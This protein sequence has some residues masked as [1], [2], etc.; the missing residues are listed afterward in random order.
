MAETSRGWQ[1]LV[2]KPEV[3]NNKRRAS[4]CANLSSTQASIDSPRGIISAQWTCLQNAGGSGTCQVGDE[5]D[6]VNLQCDGGPG[7]TIKS[8]DFASFGTPTGSCAAGGFVASNCSA[9]HSVAVVSKLCLGK[10]KCSIDVTTPTFGS[11][12]CFDT[13]KQLAVKVSCTASAP[14]KASPKFSYDVVIPTGTT[15]EVVL[16][17]FGSAVAEISEGTPGASV[18]K[19]GAYVPGVQGISGASVDKQGNVAI[20]VGSGSYA[21]TVSA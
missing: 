5:H 8:V 19:A 17:Q 18:W 21:F 12:P 16:P 4:V 1:Q 9:P 6:T 11:D 13:P 2:L 15:A 20:S 3:W 14:T 10:N 7:S